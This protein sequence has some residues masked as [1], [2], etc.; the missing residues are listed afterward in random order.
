[1][2]ALL[3]IGCGEDRVA[4]LT[5][6]IGRDGQY[7]LE[8]DDLIFSVDPAGARITDVHLHDG[9]NLL[10]GST[11]N[12]ISYGSTFW[13]SPQSGWGWPP[14]PEIDRAAFQSSVHAATLSFGGSIDVAL[15]ARVSKRFTA[16]VAGSRI[17]VQYTIT[18]QGPGKMFAPWE[19]TR[20]FAGGLTFFPTGV[21][22]PTGGA[23]LSPP[24][25][26]DAAGCTWYQSPG[27]PAGVDQ[28]LLADGAG[29]WLAHVAGDT[30]LVK[31]F[32]DVPA[33]GAAPGEAEIEIF[34]Q[35]QGGYVEIEQQGAYQSFAQGQS[36][37]WP[38]T[39]IVRRLPQ[40]MMATTGSVELVQ[41]VESLVKP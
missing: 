3:G 31:K 1:M 5:Y 4:G 8:L 39:W 30:V 18:A 10:T 27:T 36:L 29:G 34:A 17:D 19:I 14:P 15:G 41:F 21:G 28:K 38:V 24:P 33:G 9:A 25:T 7:V 20:V 37:T 16:D 22:G 35:G 26:Q 11:V 6:P 40:G 23:A 2:A 13:T 32:A 12:P